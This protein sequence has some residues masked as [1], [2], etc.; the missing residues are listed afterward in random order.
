MG[1]TGPVTKDTS[2]VAVGLAQIRVGISATHVA[3][4]TPVLTA[5]DSM[6]A[7]ADTKFNTTAEYWKLESGFP[8]LEDLSI[9]LKESASLECAFKEI[10]PKNMALAR[11][12]D[13]FSVGTGWVFSGISKV[14][15][16]GG[17]VDAAK[18]PI[19]PGAGTI[20]DTFTIT[21]TSATAYG[22]TAMSGVAVA[23]TGA[24]GSVSAF[25]IDTSAAF[26]LPANFITGTIAAGDVFRFTT[27]KDGYADNHAGVI[28][29]GGLKAPEFVRM[30]AVYTYPNGTNTLT[31]IFP[32]ANVTS[33]MEIA[34]Q[35]ADNAA[36]AITFEA[37]RAD[38]EVVGGAAAWDAMPLGVIVFG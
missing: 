33:S 20:V 36:P 32:R 17:V 2:T 24:I 31:I 5:A 10:T 14:K 25:T 18:P 4:A 23:G 29:L 22:V 21:F 1:R 37:K 6:G 30:E 35:A 19:T 27:Q 13:P 3:T 38:S 9:P 11:G 12:I 15:S 26:S 7:L 8:A 34:F 16:A 28:G